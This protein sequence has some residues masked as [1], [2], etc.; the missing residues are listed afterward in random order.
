MTIRTI[1]IVTAE[2]PTSHNIPSCRI[3]LFD[4]HATE[5]RSSTGNT[6][7][8]INTP[9][10]SPRVLPPI[11]E[12]IKMYHRPHPPPLSST[13]FSMPITTSVIPSQCSPLPFNHPPFS[14]FQSSTLN[15]P[16]CPPRLI[17]RPTVLPTIV[18]P[19]G[20]YRRLHPLPFPYFTSTMPLSSAPEPCL[21]P[22]PSAP[23]STQ[24]GLS[25]PLPQI[26]TVRMSI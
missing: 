15:I 18:Q 3:R 10:S 17:P 22:S 1:F 4:E 19:V 16:I 14:F 26:L 20:V 11:V 13:N 24:E 7:S 2:G 12:P 6:A 21:Y 23:P 9:I 25:S 8:A 5:K